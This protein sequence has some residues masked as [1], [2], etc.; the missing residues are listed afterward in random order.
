MVERKRSGS[1]AN[2]NASFANLLPFLA[3]E[4]R[5]DFRAEIKAISDIANSP[6]N[7]IRT[8]MIKISFIN[9]Q[10]KLV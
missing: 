10:A 2:F 7:K 1:F 5:L 4:D 6:F 3:S 8:I 9:S